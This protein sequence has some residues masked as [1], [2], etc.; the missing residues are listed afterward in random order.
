MIFGPCVLP[1]FSTVSGVWNFWSIGQYGNNWSCHS[2]NDEWIC[3][4]MGREFSSLWLFWS[5]LVPTELYQEVF[6]GGLKLRRRCRL[7]FCRRLWSWG[8]KRGKLSKDDDNAVCPLAASWASSSVWCRL[9]RLLR[10]ILPTVQNSRHSDTKS[11]I[12]FENSNQKK[13]VD[14][15]G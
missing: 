9:W 11:H 8:V 7:L 15:F 4:E 5:S 1:H 2:M 3:K 13:L 12:W 6:N 14:R 10:L